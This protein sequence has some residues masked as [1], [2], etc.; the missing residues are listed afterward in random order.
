MGLDK[1]SLSQRK[2]DFT[3][4]DKH[5]EKRARMTKQ[6]SKPYFRDWSNLRFF[7]GKVFKA[8]ERLFRGDVSLWFPNFFG[9]TL[10]GDAEKRDRK[11]GYGGLGRDSCVVMEGKI[12]VVSLVSNAWAQAQV[13]S[14]CSESQNPELHQVLKG[15]TDVAQQVVI[16]VEENPLRWWLLQAFR[17]SLRAQRTKEEQDCYFMVRRGLDDM[18]KESIGFLNEKVGYVYL[19]DQE[20]KIRWAGSA[21]AEPA[22][23]ESMVKGLRRLIQDVKAPDEKTNGA[24]KVD[25]GQ[26]QVPAA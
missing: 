24:V 14:F 13:D 3:N 26:K 2:Q 17:G 1:R 23:R 19:V 4:Y 16:N 6:I 8:N 20:C 5:L 7:K 25:K 11:D 15:N 9:K 10:R 12:S 22:E 21:E 18:M